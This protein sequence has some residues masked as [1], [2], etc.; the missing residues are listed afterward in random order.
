MASDRNPPANGGPGDDDRLT[1]LY[2]TEFAGLLR[3]AY[4]MTS[5]EFAGYFRVLCQ[6]QKNRRGRKP[7]VL[8]YYGTVVKRREKHIYVAIWFYIATAITVA[9]LHVVNSLE[10]P[11][12]AFKSYSMYAGVQDALAPLWSRLADGCHPNRDTVGMLRA[13]GFS[14]DEIVP[15][16]GGLVVGIRARA[17]EAA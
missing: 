9:V 17:P 10:I 13:G 8:N 14:V 12:T 7:F 5:S 2:R 1:V 15:H 6:R 4:S 3:L 11:V 16:L